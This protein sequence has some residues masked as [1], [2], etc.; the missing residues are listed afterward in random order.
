[1]VSKQQESFE[2]FADQG[3][4]RPE[5]AK[6]QIPEGVVKIQPHGGGW[7]L[8]GIGRAKS[9]KRFNITRGELAELLRVAAEQ[10]LS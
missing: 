2:Q 6:E 8:V 1:M 10:G 5:L 4:H 7:L 9:V 3:K